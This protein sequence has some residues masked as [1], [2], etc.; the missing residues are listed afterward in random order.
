MH[1][2]HLT[3]FPKTSF[4]IPSSDGYQLYSSLLNIIKESN[5][6]TSS[7]IHN[8]SLPSISLTGLSGPFKKSEKTGQKVIQSGFLYQWRI[9]I[10]EPSDESVY[11]TIIAPFLLSNKE[12]SLNKGTLSVDKIE[13]TSTTFEEIFFK[14]SN[15]VNPSIIFQFISP[16][17]IQYKNSKVTEMFPQRIAVFYSILSKYNQVCPE[18]YKLSISRD[19]FGRYLIEYPDPNH[20]QTHSILTN[21][22]FDA[23]KQHA[24][25]IFKQGFTGT[26]KY[27]FTPD[28][29]SSFRNA[30]LIL[31]Q[32]AEYSGIGSSVSRGCGQIK[33]TIQEGK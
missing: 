7:N 17:C 15:Y 33:L 29:T 26:C 8:T 1:L 20:Y 18:K 9:G 16:T 21:T 3:L 2:I 5:P 27:A 11:Q 24:R 12:I 13:S 14:I 19:D 22:I 10:S 28:A 32:F 31:S 25:P 30:C 6:K 4:D 23:K